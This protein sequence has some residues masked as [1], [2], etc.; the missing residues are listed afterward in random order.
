MNDESRFADFLRKVRGGDARAAEDLVRRYS[1]GREDPHG[2]SE[3]FVA[4]A[5]LGGMAPGKG[6]PRSPGS[7]RCRPNCWRHR[8]FAWLV[9]RAA[10]GSRLS[11]GH[12][13]AP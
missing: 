2:R 1:L 7:P 5:E 3:Q 11:P 10:N 8:G 9:S 4:G 12:E 13:E 6:R